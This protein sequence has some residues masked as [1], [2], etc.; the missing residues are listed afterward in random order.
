MKKQ[1]LKLQDTVVLLAPVGE[2][3]VG[4]VGVI[5]EEWDAEHFE[6]EFVDAK[7]NTIGFSAVSKAEL[8]R[9]YFNPKAA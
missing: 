4:Q 2:F 3:V 8:L 5:V 7:A 9:L 1:E 6:V